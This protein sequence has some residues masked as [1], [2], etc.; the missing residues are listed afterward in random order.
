MTSNGESDDTDRDLVVLL[1][2][3]F[4]PRTLAGLYACAEL[5]DWQTIRIERA[6]VHAWSDSRLSVDREDR[7]VAL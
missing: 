4:G 6:V 1:L 7:L 3:R 2:Q 5:A